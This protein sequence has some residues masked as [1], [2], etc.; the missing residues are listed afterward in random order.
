MCWSL[1][2]S[3]LISVVELSI[4][5]FIWRRNALGDR[6]LVKICASVFFVEFSEMLQWTLGPPPVRDFHY[7]TK[8][9]KFACGAVETSNVIYKIPALMAIIS[10][11]LQQHFLSIWLQGLLKSKAGWRS[12]LLRV[13][14]L[15]SRLRALV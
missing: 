4:I 1:E 6:T 10:V 13:V 8:A 15:T 9:S 12:G 3:V 2:V 11:D 5:A 14:S 7:A